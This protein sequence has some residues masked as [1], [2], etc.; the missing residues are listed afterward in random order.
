MAA[1]ARWQDLST[2]LISGAGMAAVGIGVIAL[3]GLAFRVLAALVAAGIVWELARMLSRPAMP[4]APVL[5]ALAMGVVL[6][7]RVLPSGAVALVALP[8]MLGAAWLPTRRAAFAGFALA[9][10]MASAGLA[11][12]RDSQGVTWLVW[13]LLVVISTDIFGY[14][15]GRAIG[16]PRFWPAV[17]PGKTWSGLIAGW[18]AAALIGGLFAIAT[19]SGAALAGVS[20]ALA[21]SAQA[22]DMA[23]SALKR[24]AGVKDSSGL[25]PGHGGLFDRFDGVLGAALFALLLQVLGAVPEVTL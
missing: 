11:G 25:L 18:A 5:G 6:A 7:L 23:E 4:A 22:G 16:G 17:S 19:E 24:S 14:L 15:A 1:A 3:G 8:A 21:I 20:M 2:R 10:V 13:L 12:F 9:A